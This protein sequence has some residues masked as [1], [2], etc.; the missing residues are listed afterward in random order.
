MVQAVEA[1]FPRIIVVLNTGGMM[2]T[3]WFKD[4]AKI[5]AA[6]LA[7]QGGI[8][9]GL[10]MA[11]VLCGDVCPSGHLTDTFATDFSAYPSSD[12]FNESEDYV[13]LEFTM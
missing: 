3:L 5:Q 9:G 2:D 13:E 8:E 11:D 1:A 6:L 4:N 12:T 7:W 10:A